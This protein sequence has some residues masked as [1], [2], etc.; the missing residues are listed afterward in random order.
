MAVDGEMRATLESWGVTISD[1]DI[2]AAEAIRTQMMPQQEAVISKYELDAELVDL[3]TQ[4][5]R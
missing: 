5:A 4:A 2:A 1:A 3:A